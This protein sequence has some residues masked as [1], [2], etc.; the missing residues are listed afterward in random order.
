MLVLR[1]PGRPPVQLCNPRCQATEVDLVQVWSRVGAGESD[2]KKIHHLSLIKVDDTD[3]AATYLACTMS[4]QSTVA[5]LRCTLTY[6][7]VWN[8]PTQRGDGGAAAVAGSVVVPAVVYVATGS[9]AVDKIDMQTGVAMRVLQNACAAAGSGDRIANL[10]ITPLFPN[11][12]WMTRRDGVYPFDITDVDHVV[13]E[14][15]DMTTIRVVDYQILHD[16]SEA[17]RSNVIRGSA[18]ESSS[19]RFSNITFPPR[20]GHAIHMGT[21]QMWTVNASGCLPCPA[22]T[23]FQPI[24]GMTHP[25]CRAV[26]PGMYVIAFGQKQEDCSDARGEVLVGNLCKCR[27][28][29]FSINTPSGIGNCRP[30]PVGTFRSEAGGVGVQSCTACSQPNTTTLQEA[31]TRE[32]QCVCTSLTFNTTTIASTDNASTDNASRRRRLSSAAGCNCVGC[33]EGTASSSGGISSSGRGG[34]WMQVRWWNLS[35]EHGGYRRVVF[36]PDAEDEVFR[37][38]RE[39]FRTVFRLGEF[40]HTAQQVYWESLSIIAAP[41]A[42]VQQ[43]PWGNLFRVGAVCSCKNKGEI[44]VVDSSERV[45]CLTCPKGFFCPQDPDALNIDVY[46]LI[47]DFKIQVIPY[48]L[49]RW[50]KSSGGA[51]LCPGGV[52]HL[53]DVPSLPNEPGMGATSVEECIPP[54]VLSPTT[55]VA[56]CDTPGYAILGEQKL[57]S[58]CSLPTQFSTSVYPLTESGGQ[59]ITGCRECDTE[60]RPGMVAVWLNEETGFFEDADGL[61]ANT[62]CA[63]KRGMYTVWDPEANMTKCVVCPLEGF[64]CP[65]LSDIAVED[66]LSVLPHDQNT[67]YGWWMLKVECP[68]PPHPDAEHHHQAEPMS[69]EGKVS[70]DQCWFWFDMDAEGNSTILDSEGNST[71][72]DS[73]G[74]STILDSEG[75]STSLDSEGNSTILDSEGNSTILDSEDNGMRRRLLLAQCTASE[76][77]C[78]IQQQLCSEGYYCPGDGKMYPCPSKYGLA[79]SPG[80]PGSFSRVGASDP[81]LHCGCPPNMHLSAETGGC[82]YCPLFP[83]TISPGGVDGACTCSGTHYG[84]STWCTRCPSLTSTLD[85]PAFLHT[86]NASLR[87]YNPPTTTLQDCKPVRGYYRDPATTVVTLCPAGSYCPFGSDDTRQRCPEH[88]T[89]LYKLIGMWNIQNCTC[90]PGYYMDGDEQCTPC[91]SGFFCPGNNLKL[92]CSLSPLLSDPYAASGTMVRARDQGCGCLPGYWVSQ[93]DPNELCIPVG[94]GYYSTFPGTRSRIPCGRG[95]VAS[96]NG[97]SN[98]TSASEA[99]TCARGWTGTP[100]SFPGCTP[101]PAGSFCPSSSEREIQTC[102][103][104]AVCPEGSWV[105]TLCS[106][107]LRIQGATTLRPGMA[108]AEQD[109]LC[110]RGWGFSTVQSLSRCVV[111]P[112]GFECPRS[113]VQQTGFQPCPPDHFCILG[114]KLPCPVGSSA[115]VQAARNS[116]RDCPCLPRWKRTSAGECIP[117]SKYEVCPGGHDAP[118]WMCPVQVDPECVCPVDGECLISSGT[119]C[120]PPERGYFCPPGQSKQEPC[121]IPGSEALSL[122]LRPCA[123]PMGTYED[124]D[125]GRCEPCP[126]GHSCLQDTPW[127]C[128]EEDGNLFQSQTEPCA[129]NLDYMRDPSNAAACIPCPSPGYVCVHGE[130]TPCPLG[131]T[132]VHGECICLE[133]YTLQGETCAPCPAGVYCPDNTTQILCTPG[134][135]CPSGSAAPIPCGPGQTSEEQ[136]DSCTCLEGKLEDKDG[137][138]CS[139]CPAAGY[140][141][142]NTVCDCACPPGQALDVECKSCVGCWGAGSTEGYGGSYTNCLSGAVPML[143]FQEEPPCPKG[144]R[145]T[146]GTLKGP[147]QSV[148]YPC[149]VDHS[150]MTHVC[151][152]GGGS[153]S[154][155]PSSFTTTPWIL[156]DNHGAHE[157]GGWSFQGGRPM[158]ATSVYASSYE[159]CECTAAGEVPL[160]CQYSFDHPDFQSLCFCW[161]QVPEAFRVPGKRYTSRKL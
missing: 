68:P 145:C 35:M 144:F 113:R 159:E 29:Y 121:P 28:G 136:A 40:A 56:P 123:C 17:L 100:G 31:C 106:T 124:L 85:M 83:V 122:G 20:A 24:D 2:K 97:I 18:A 55:E 108:T 150:H 54:P 92:S 142:L 25:Y 71:S 62:R 23:H 117:C 36:D 94:V 89:T 10:Q 128:V 66:H 101:C 48:P 146:K 76:P 46:E 69:M 70:A 114:E 5:V 107:F 53:T 9:C 127:L 158:R 140:A 98:A 86:V 32:D 96:P 50:G 80:Q 109:C 19:S 112:S 44:F 126:P 84:N 12:L 105:P 27:K 160:E 13:T 104:G 91:P 14:V 79:Q 61:H 43:S 6:C 21:G 88:S 8:Q 155:V 130:A 7:S 151:D 37:Y 78:T 133:G 45:A 42:A 59:G 26:Q 11:W 81:D 3:T 75:N 148:A 33:P 90:F 147:Q 119:R 57:C 15:S 58:K 93:N 149:N 138:G 139:S 87:H 72:L 82:S 134:Y 67:Y 77:G 4:D 99:C 125:A 65:G 137:L 154:L 118:A 116:S 161:T 1:D 22:D 64:F 111:C 110:P 47:L 95:E 131:M 51:V 153:L 63:C 141:D 115:P 30:C 135:M 60:G 120:G 73:E 152:E 74:N 52:A 38:T 39:T 102:P 41:S 16:S 103:V 132:G 156:N 129:C 157:C 143:H 34:G 49:P